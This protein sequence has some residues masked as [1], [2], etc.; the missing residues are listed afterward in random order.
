MWLNIRFCISK[1]RLLLIS[2]PKRDLILAEIC[3]GVAISTATVSLALFL[4]GLPV[5]RLARVDARIG[6]SYDAA[7]PWHSLEFSFTLV[8]LFLFTVSLLRLLSL[9][10]IALLESWN[11]SFYLFRDLI[12]QTLRYLHSLD[13]AVLHFHCHFLN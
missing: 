2:K 6:Q 12:L 10:L 11:L 1:R 5:G 8:S 7:S 9:N 3:G 13:C 4:V